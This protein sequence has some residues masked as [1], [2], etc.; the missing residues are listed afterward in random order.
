MSNH[1]LEKA[2][3]IA[4]IVDAVVATIVWIAPPQSS[5]NDAKQSA[6]RSSDA[7]E[8]PYGVPTHRL[9]SVS[10]VTMSN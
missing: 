8:K 5:S 6:P 9:A 2:S 3:W 7:P 10:A 4:G 1:P